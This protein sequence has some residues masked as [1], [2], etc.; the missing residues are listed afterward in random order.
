MVT[1]GTDVARA[2]TPYPDKVENAKSFGQAAD[3]YESIRPGYP[4]EALEWMIPAEARSVV[5]VGAGTGKFTRM[6]AATGRDVA[7]VE[8]D[9]AMLERLAAALPS[10]RA[11]AGSAESLPLEDASVDAVTSAQAWHW[12]DPERALPEVARVLRPGGTL[13]AVWNILDGSVEWVVALS[14]AVGGSRNGG[15]AV[16]LAAGPA[17]GPVERTAFPWQ[18]PLDRAG[19]LALVTSWSQYLV[20]PADERARILARVGAVLD[21][22]GP[23]VYPLP[24]KAHCFRARLVR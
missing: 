22:L 17:F 16:E 15:G 2:G 4:A 21:G 9:P 1:R 3:V 14:E 19:V 5:D 23:D 10:V 7:A 11:L 6:L 18:Y 12:V 20:A 24:Y 8:P 13:A